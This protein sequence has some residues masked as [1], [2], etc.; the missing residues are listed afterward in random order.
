MQ[1]T[2][3]PE[4]TQILETL[5]KQGQYSSVEEA[6]NTALQLLINDVA[7]REAWLRLSRHQLNNAYTEDDN[8]P[9]Y[10]IKIAN[11]DYAGS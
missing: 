4:Q 8:Y 5:L 9:L 2:L 10:A 7:E 11:P 6:I 3:N 1:I